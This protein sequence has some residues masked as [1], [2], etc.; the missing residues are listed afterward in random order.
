MSRLIL[1]GDK[2]SVDNEAI[3][4]LVKEIVKM[5]RTIV[6]KSKFDRTVKGKI[7]AIDEENKLY[8]IIIGGNKY[9]AV[10]CVGNLSI[11]DIVYVTIAENNYN[12]LIILTKTNKNII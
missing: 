3:Q 12:D 2:L 4:I 6:N 10:S 5:I 8:T 11:N 1:G 9:N 7:T